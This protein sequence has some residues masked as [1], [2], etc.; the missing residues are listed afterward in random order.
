[1]VQVF[2]R[3]LWSL[4]N[5]WL[6]AICQFD[7]PVETM[8]R[9]IYKA[10]LHYVAT[11]WP[12]Q[13]HLAQKPKRIIYRY[14]VENW[15]IHSSVCFLISCKNIS[16]WGNL[17]VR[18]SFEVVSCTF[19]FAFTATTTHVFLFFFACLFLLPSPEAHIKWFLHV[20][21]Q[22]A[23]KSRVEN[24]RAFAR[25]L[26]AIWGVFFFLISF[27]KG[28]GQILSSSASLTERAQ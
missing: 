25:D 9:V 22:E 21:S 20:V 12:N 19:T 27:R 3:Y 13:C 28:R 8:V 26:H 18:L 14:T 7:P 10:R 2:C 5:R 16:D 11:I 6:K 23:T 17:W 4:V 24:V 1:M 15:Q